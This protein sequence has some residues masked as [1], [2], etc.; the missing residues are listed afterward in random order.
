MKLVKVFLVVCCLSINVFSYAAD[1][2]PLVMLKSTSSKMLQ[3]LNKHLGN[4]KNNNQLIYNLVNKILVPH[5]DLGAMASAVV[6][7]YWLKASKDTQQRFMEEFTRYIIRT[8][9]SALQAYDGETIKFYPIR[10]GFGEKVQISSDLFL[11]NG[12]PIQIRYSLSYQ[13][14]KWLVY[15]FSVD[16]V[17][18]VKNYNSQFSGVLRQSGLEG[19]VRKLQ[20]RSLVK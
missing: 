3:E 6:G 11:K 2:E 8:Y 15:D 10:S 7:P 19:L 18:I 13:Q 20:Q 16:G 4:L 1:P 17:S 14:G 5:F 12:P 9:S